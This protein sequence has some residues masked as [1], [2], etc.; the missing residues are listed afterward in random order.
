MGILDD[1]KNMKPVIDKVFTVK[2]IK[3]VIRKLNKIYIK[4]NNVKLIR[5]NSEIEYIK[6]NFVR[7]SVGGLIGNKDSANEGVNEN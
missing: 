5:N 1:I 6:R 4:S 2:N 7:L 3:E